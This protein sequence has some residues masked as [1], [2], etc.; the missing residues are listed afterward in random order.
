MA[1]Q[2]DAALGADK[3]AVAKSTVGGLGGSISVRVIVD[4]GVIGSR[5]AARLALEAI[6]QRIMEDTWPPA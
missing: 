4:E 1:K 2:F 6:E 3:L 5:T